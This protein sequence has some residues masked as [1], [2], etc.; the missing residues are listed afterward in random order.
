MTSSPNYVVDINTLSTCMADPCVDIDHLGA[1]WHLRAIADFDGN[2]VDDMLWHYSKNERFSIWL[3][4]K[5]Q[6]IDNSEVRLDGTPINLNSSEG[7]SLL[8]AARFDSDSKADILWLNKYSGVV[9]MWLM[10]GSEILSFDSVND[11]NG[12][13]KRLGIDNSNWLYSGYGS[14]FDS[15]AVLWYNIT[16]HASYIWKMD[17][18]TIKEVITVADS[19]TAI[20]TLEVDKKTGVVGDTFTFTGTGFSWGGG[21]VFHIAGP[22]TFIV[23]RT[24]DNNGGISYSDSFSAAGTYTITA[25]DDVSNISAPPV[26][27]TVTGSSTTPTLTVDKTTGVVGDEFAF[28]GKGFTP[29]GEVI[30]IAYIDEGNGNG[31]YEYNESITANSSGMVLYTLQLKH[32]ATYTA[33]AFDV[34]TNKE[35]NA[36]TITVK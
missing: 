9:A 23:G 4:N 3:M 32:V 21:V 27:I 6:I 28:S 24:A 17:G 36:I 33:S 15:N 19:Q 10:N 14:L 25:T 7:W 12:K 8:E 18:A 34:T 16:D 26:T 2:G 13:N 29:N 5:N 11:T 30:V 35:T 22:Q 31:Y 20:P 1:E